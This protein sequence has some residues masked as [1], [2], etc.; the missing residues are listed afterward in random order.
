MNEQLEMLVE[1]F[2]DAM[3]ELAA[4]PGNE[5][6]V[7]RHLR[8]YRLFS[9]LTDLRELTVQSLVQLITQIEKSTG[10]AD[11]IRLDEVLKWMWQGGKWVAKQAAA[12]GLWGAATAASKQ[13]DQDVTID[14]IS[15]TDPL[16]IKS[17]NLEKLLL[18]TQEMIQNLSDTLAKSM[19]E[20]DDSIDYNTAQEA[21]VDINDVQAAQAMQMAPV[22]KKDKVSKAVDKE[23]KTK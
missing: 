8:Q 14:G 18:S 3:H 16:N 22:S 21:N 10:A 19:K 23:E 15:T 9:E 13:V 17:P 20:L 7:L 2:V 1:E 12:L 5:S 4:G 11:S 6:I